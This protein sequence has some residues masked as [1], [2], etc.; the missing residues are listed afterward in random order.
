MS[1]LPRPRLPLCLSLLSLP[2][3]AC[4]DPEA[5]PEPAP[6]VDAWE[7]VA[8][9]PA[10]ALDFLEIGSALSGDNFAN[11]GDVTIEYVE[12]TDQITVEMQRFGSYASTDQRDENF[13][14]IEGW[15]YDQSSPSIPTADMAAIACWAPETSGCHVSVYYDGQS[16]P[17]RAGANFRVQ[18]PVGWPGDLSVETEDN[19][20]DGP[21][22][23]PDRSDVRILGAR[24]NV[25][26]LLDSGNV[27]IRLDPDIPHYAGCSDSQACEEH[28]GVAPDPN[29]E[30]PFACG[31]DTPTNIAVENRAGQ[32]SNVTV[33]VATADNWY[34]VQLENRGD[35]SAQSDFIC[36]AAIECAAFDDCAIDPDY[37]ATDNEE[38]AEI[39]FPGVNTIEGTGIRIVAT[40]EQCSFVPYTEG[41]EDFEADP[42]PEQKRGQL[43]V[44]VGCL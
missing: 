36:D 27:D 5:D 31:C 13:A 3:A 26:V 35:F 41:P 23:Y 40:S 39:N 44:C 30:E 38:R 4:G 32:S 6:M 28:F 19:L 9:G 17:V 34:T 12:G 7:V 16:Q 22:T 11:R 1:R 37:A 14:R 10:S 15:A 18:I 33:D 2:L 8:Q 43:D 29:E 25:D 20:A 21:T 42:M 24:G